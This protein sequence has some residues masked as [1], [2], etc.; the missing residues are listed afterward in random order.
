M[1]G[2]MDGLIDSVGNKV[3]CRRETRIHFSESSCHDQD[4][5]EI[6]TRAVSRTFGVMV[7]S[8]LLPA[9]IESVFKKS[10]DAKCL[11]L[12]CTTR[13]RHLVLY[14]RASPIIISP[15]TCFM[16]CTV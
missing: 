11:D 8:R 1:D 4:G 12:I 7:P 9:S 5:L 13:T 2:W 3:R 16:S 6:R 15:W 10:V 14:V